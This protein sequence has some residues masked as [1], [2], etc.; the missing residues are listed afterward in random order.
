M[1]QLASG[2]YRRFPARKLL[3]RTG[4]IDITDTEGNVLYTSGA[5]DKQKYSA[6]ALMCRRSL[7]GRPFISVSTARLYMAYSAVAVSAMV[8]VNTMR[9]RSSAN[10][11]RPFHL[12][13]IFNFVPQSPD[14]FD[15]ARVFGVVFHLIPQ[16][17]DMHHHGVFITLEICAVSG[18]VQLHLGENAP[19]RFH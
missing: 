16:L 14:G 7:P 15:I 11:S 8:R 5:A 4:Y 18:F 13:C 9:P 1:P 6:T 10:A 17:G 2:E 3:G 12:L 19:R